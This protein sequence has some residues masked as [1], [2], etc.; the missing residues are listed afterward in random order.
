MTVSI[1][2]LFFFNFIQK[3]QVKLQDISQDTSPQQEQVPEPS[4][5]VLSVVAKKDAWARI[6]ANENRLFEIFLKKEVKYRWNVKKNF[7][8][9]LS[10]ANSAEVSLNDKKF[11]NVTN[12]NEILFLDI[13]SFDLND[14]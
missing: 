6:S 13:N 12:E 10:T 3:E 7:A 8:I 4:N 5:L 1:Y 11:K 14:G 2:F 9:I